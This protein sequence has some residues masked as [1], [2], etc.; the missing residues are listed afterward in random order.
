MH[1]FIERTRAASP[2]LLALSGRCHATESVPYQGMDQIVDALAHYLRRVEPGEIETLLPRNFGLLARLFPV[3]AQFQKFANRRLQEVVDR[4]EMRKRVFLAL[5]EMVGRIAERR[6]VIIALDDVQWADEDAL[7]ALDELVAGPAA[8]P[9]LIV[10]AYR[11]EDAPL[12]SRRALTSPAPVTEVVPLAGLDSMETS[13]LATSLA[14][15]MPTV[16]F[17]VISALVEESGGATRFWHESS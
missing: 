1:A 6:P 14:Q 5:R 12:L 3:M 13:A 8:P 16:S 9:V 7:A 10:L 2:D 4:A 17:S 15:A 11:S